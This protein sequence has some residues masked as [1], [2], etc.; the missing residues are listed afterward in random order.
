MRPWQQAGACATRIG[1]I[2][3]PL[4]TGLKEIRESEVMAEAL[5]T[6]LVSKGAPV[7]LKGNPLMTVLEEIREGEVM[8]EASA[9]RLVSKGLRV[10]L[11]RD[12]LMTCLKEIRESEVIVIV[13]A[14]SAGQ[15]GGADLRGFKGD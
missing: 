4:M 11:T 6:R 5:A 1:F 14:D 9:T 8:T 13:A 12:A 10:V 15:V 3:N 2:G 7:V